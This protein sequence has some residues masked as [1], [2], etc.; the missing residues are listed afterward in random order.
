MGKHPPVV[1]LLT[2]TCSSIIEKALSFRE[3]SLTENATDYALF[4][5]REG[6]D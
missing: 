3:M 5:E 4:D 6:D 2:F 1:D